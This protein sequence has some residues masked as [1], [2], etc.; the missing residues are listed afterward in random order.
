MIQLQ[1]CDKCISVYLNGVS[2]GS[3][4]LYD[5]PCH[6]KCCYIR[7]DG[8]NLGCLSRESS[9]ELFEKLERIA[10]RPLQ[11]MV[12]SSDAET[13]G[14][15]TAGGFICKRKCYEVE[16]CEKDYT[17]GAGEAELDF[18]HAGE[19]EYELCCKLM[20]E[21]YIEIH[22]AVNPWT[23]GLYDFCAAL[24]GEAVYERCDGAIVNLAF[25]E[26]NEIAYICTLN[27]ER[28]CGFAASLIQW[29]FSGY[30]TICFESDDCDDAAMQLRAM[31]ISRKTESFDTY[32][33]HGAAGRE[34]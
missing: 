27:E 9:A 15:L 1:Q 34:E 23:A 33:F 13:V 11:A 3:V 17:G 4:A 7:L 6:R 16:A 20:Y 29:L 32:I 21:R 31:F 18:V 25:L 22:R 26:K 5:N 24:P 14:F 19:P 8:L 30:E 10:R 2:V 12:S 28:F